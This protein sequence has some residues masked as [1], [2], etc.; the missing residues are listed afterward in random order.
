MPVSANFITFKNN[1]RINLSVEV[2]SYFHMN[3]FLLLRQYV[4]MIFDVGF[5]SV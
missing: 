2:D 3:L 4:M 1:F 5:L